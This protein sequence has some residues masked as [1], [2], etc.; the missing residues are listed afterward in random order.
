MNVSNYYFILVIG[1]LCVRKAMRSI[2]ATINILT[3][4]RVIAFCRKESAIASLATLA[5]T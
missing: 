3:S 4:G 1:G 2:I 5:S